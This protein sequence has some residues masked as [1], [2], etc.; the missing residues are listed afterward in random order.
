[1]KPYP[2]AKIVAVERPLLA[3]CEKAAFP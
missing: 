1:M 2:E 3:T